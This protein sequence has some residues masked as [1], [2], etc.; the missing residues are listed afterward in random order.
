MDNIELI[1]YRRALKR[2]Y[3]STHTLKSYMNILNHFLR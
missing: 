1:H 2:K 3:Y